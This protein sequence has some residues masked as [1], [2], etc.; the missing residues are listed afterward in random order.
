MDTVLCAC[1]QD[2]NTHHLISISILRSQQAPRSILAKA[3]CF[4]A[5]LTTVKSV[6]G[7]YKCEF[8]LQFV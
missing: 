8:P 6:E 4:P 2:E 5:L 7:N 3:L 1:F